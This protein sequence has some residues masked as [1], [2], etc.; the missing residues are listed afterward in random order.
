MESSVQFQ[1]LEQYAKQHTRFSAP[2]DSDLDFNEQYVQALHEHGYTEDDAFFDDYMYQVET[3][4]DRAERFL[5]KRPLTTAIMALRNDIRRKYF[6][7][8]ERNSDYVIYTSDVVLLV[9]MLS[10]LCGNHDC[11]EHA[12]F[13]FI[14]NPILQYI[15]PDMPS[16]KWMIS[17]E[18]IRF[19]L[20]MIPDDE[21]SSMFRQYFSDA[22]IEAYELV[23]NIRNEDDNVSDYRH[24]LGGDGQELRSSFRR[25]EKSRK[26]KGAHRVSLYD[27]SALNVISYSMVKAKNN[28][29]SAFIEMIDNGSLPQDSI[30]YAD[31][32]NTTAK[33]IEFLNSRYLDYIMAVKTN[34]SNRPVVMAMEKYISEFTDKTQNTSSHYHEV[35]TDK[36][37]SRIEERTYDIVPVE[38]LLK[39]MD[40]LK[41]KDGGDILTKED[42][43]PNTRTVI[44]V[45]K[46]T[47]SH[48]KDDKEDGRKVPSTLYFISSL[49]FTEEN[50]HQ[51]VFSLR[52]RWMYEAQHNIIDTVLLQDMQ[53]CCDENHLASVIGLNS[54]VYNVISFAREKM[55]KR[56]Y[57]NIKHRTKETARKAPLISYKISF[58]IF[59]NNPLLALA[60]LMEYF[61]TQTVE[62]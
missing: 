49:P 22:R 60:Y 51:T 5:K 45:Y 13:Y 9:V 53:H 54:M 34:L 18:E 24:L 40:G 21:F 20:K 44:R 15:I 7:Y 56:G 29:V 12:K 52:S 16:P 39:A 36:E 61:D 25:G 43:L 14:Y 62:S 37:G 3:A 46:E 28:E 11:R 58:K 4:R 50:C 23:H 33:M 55:S 31:A 47:Q 32:I 41:D 57:D 1:E 38:S 19:F 17:A 26:K 8:D 59:E 30:F 6:Q 35:R 2:A 48:L 10:S 27:C 42:I